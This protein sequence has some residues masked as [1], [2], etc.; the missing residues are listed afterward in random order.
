MINLS[1]YSLHSV[2]ALYTN[3]NCLCH[4]NTCSSRSSVLGSAFVLDAAA[5]CYFSYH[6]L[7][8]GDSWALTVD[9]CIYIVG[10]ECEGMQPQWKNEDYFQN[11]LDAVR[12]HR[13]TKPNSA[14]RQ[15]SCFIQ[16]E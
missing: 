12:T 13:P 11:R 16:N 4:F 1:Y 15:H 2:A 14:A 6:R 7:Q 5:K 9:V 8:R 10:I 3:N